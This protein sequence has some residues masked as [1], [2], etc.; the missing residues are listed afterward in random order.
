M[1]RSISTKDRVRLFAMHGGV[2]HMCGGRIT[3]GEAWEVSHDTPLAMGGA[4]DDANRKL[5]HKKCHRDH[6]SGVD[7]PQIAKAKRREAAHLGA[8]KPR[9]MTR[10]RKFDGTIVQKSRER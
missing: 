6:T 9:T 5:A 7:I 8:K 2:C 10:W 1:R 4:D 3:V